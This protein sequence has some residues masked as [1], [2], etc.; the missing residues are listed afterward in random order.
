MNIFCGDVVFVNI[1]V[2]NFILLLN[3]IKRLPLKKNIVKRL[4]VAELKYITVSLFNLFCR[5]MHVY[6][7]MI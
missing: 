3:L 1:F 7:Y 6:E 2:F 5:C 4:S